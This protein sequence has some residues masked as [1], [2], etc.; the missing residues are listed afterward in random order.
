MTGEN[1][2]CP[3]KSLERYSF[4]YQRHHPLLAIRKRDEKWIRPAS[5]PLNA[6]VTHPTYMTHGLVDIGLVVCGFGR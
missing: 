4:F 2:Y 1:N 3:E 5:T 6:D